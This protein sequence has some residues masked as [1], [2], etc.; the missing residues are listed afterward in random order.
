MEYQNDVIQA[1]IKDYEARFKQRQEHSLG[2]EIERDNTKFYFRKPYGKLSNIVGGNGIGVTVTQRGEKQDYNELVDFVIMEPRNSLDLTWMNRN[3]TIVFGSTPQ[4]KRLAKLEVNIDNLLGS[5]FPVSRGFG[6]LK[7]QI[8]QEF[9]K[10]DFIIHGE[11]AQLNPIQQVKA[12]C[13]M[14]SIN[15]ND[16]NSIALQGFNPVMERVLSSCAKMRGVAVTQKNDKTVDA[17]EM[18]R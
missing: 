8:K 5:F 7:S 11:N 1:E 9:Q 18:T 2:R 12:F 3:D 17:P 4:Y 16:I 6:L 15:R 14:L 10:K 13:A